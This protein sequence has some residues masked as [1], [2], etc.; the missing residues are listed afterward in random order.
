MAE[1][2]DIDDPGTRGRLVVRDRAVERV[3]VAAALDA[4]GVQRHRRGMSVLSGGDLPRAD[5]VVSGDHVRASVEIAVDWGVPLAETAGAVAV[6]VSDALEDLSGLVVDGVEVHV[7][8]VV[9]PV[10]RESK[11]RVS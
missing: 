11:R 5:V 9:N 3:A 6:R 10:A 8:A 4:D 2:T 7:A 1:Q